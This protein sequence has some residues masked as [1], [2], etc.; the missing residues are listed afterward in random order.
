MENF[1]SYLL[2]SKAILYTD[3]STHE[4]LLEKK[5]AKPRLIWWTL[6]LQEFDMEINDKKGVE[7]IVAHHLS[8]LIGE[9]HDATLNDAFSDEHLM[10]ISIGQA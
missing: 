6:L 9:S 3:H 5:Y 4:H 2:C 8:R 7:N 10:A 1:R